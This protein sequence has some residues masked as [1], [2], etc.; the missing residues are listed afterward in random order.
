MCLLEGLSL[1]SDDHDCF[2]VVRGSALANQ[3]C[4]T[5]LYQALLLI[6][7]VFEGLYSHPLRRGFQS[8]C[9][10][11]SNLEQELFTVEWLGAV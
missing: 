6:S 7:L 11:P 2:L 4:Q 5:P 10:L 3:Q 8:S 1:K 9:T